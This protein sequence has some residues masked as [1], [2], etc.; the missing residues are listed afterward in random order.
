M[1]T[2]TGSGG[3]QTRAHAPE[4]RISLTSSASAPTT[5][6]MAHPGCRET[7]YRPLHPGEVVVRVPH[8]GLGPSVATARPRREDQ[9][10]DVGDGRRGRL[11]RALRRR[12]RLQPVGTR[13]D[14]VA[15]PAQVVLGGH[16]EGFE[17]GIGQEAG[18][19]LR[20]RR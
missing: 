9:A 5:T 18:P 7:A 19:P 12:H 17:P 3:D 6:A 8:E 1:T 10:G 20:R 2:E 13:V 11:G 14:R 16:R 15:E 4:S